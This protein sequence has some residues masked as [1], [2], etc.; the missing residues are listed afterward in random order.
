M[1]NIFIFIRRNFNVLVFLFLQAISIWALVRYNQ[2]YRAKGLGVTNEVTGWFNSKY[3][4]VEDFFKMKEENKRILRM[5]DSL[6]NLLPSNFSEIDST[7]KIV[8]DTVAYDTTN[9]YRQYLWRYAQVVYNTVSNEKNYLQI[10]KGSQE[11]IRDNMGVFSSDGKLVG[12]VV[13]VSAHF[14]VV[15]SLLH[16]Q[17]NVDVMMK[18]S[19]NP[20]TISWDGEDPGLLTLTR[21]PK[22]DSLVKGDTVVTG[23]FSLSYPPGYMVGTIAKIIKDNSTNFYVLKVKPAINF[24]DLQQVMI[25]EN[26]Q[27]SELNS[28]LEAGKKKVEETR[29]K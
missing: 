9:R 7:E 22:S 12:K 5:N 2:F 6:L 10:N 19:H 25:V 8:K 15:M 3:N 1:R 20:G 17:N 11:G 29:K 24:G 16:V 28:L 26:M 4:N 27:Y 13:N 23:N 14:S 21:I 18:R